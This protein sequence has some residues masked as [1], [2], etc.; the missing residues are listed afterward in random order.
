MLDATEWLLVGP[1]RR[2]G[3]GFEFEAA[4]NLYSLISGLCVL[5]KGVD[6]RREW[7]ELLGAASDGDRTPSD[8]GGPQIR[9]K[10]ALRLYWAGRCS[11]F[12]AMGLAQESKPNSLDTLELM[13]PAHFPV[14][15]DEDLRL[16][17]LVDG[18]HYRLDLGKLCVLVESKIR[19]VLD[20]KQARD[21]IEA[22]LQLWLPD[23]AVFMLRKPVSW[24]LRPLHDA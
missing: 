14:P 11:Q 21:D 4:A 20:H 9:E 5:H 18:N 8:F 15:L 22:R 16:F 6:G 17:E 23:S 1:S 24:P 19:F 13:A 10:E 2:E 3:Y 7:Q 12:H